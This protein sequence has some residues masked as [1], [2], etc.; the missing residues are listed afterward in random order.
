MGKYHHII[1]PVT[2][3]SPRHILALWTV[4][5]TTLLADALSTALFFVEPDVLHKYSFDYAILYADKT[6]RV[7][8]SFP[9]YFFTQ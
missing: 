8:P 7:S 4:A 9:G 3:E 2:A 1:N 6:T 5:E